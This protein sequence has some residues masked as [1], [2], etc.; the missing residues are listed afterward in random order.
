MRKPASFHL[1]RRIVLLLALLAVLSS[2]MALLMPGRAEACDT[3]MSSF[4]YYSDP[5]KTD[6]VGR[7]WYCSNGTSDCFGTYP[8]PYYDHYLDP[9]SGC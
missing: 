4:E 2:S 8:T 6:W 7:C 9:C 1:P 3:R 5:A